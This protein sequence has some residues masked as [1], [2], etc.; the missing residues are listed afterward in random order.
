MKM[1][2][3]PAQK[4]L[5]KAVSSADYIQEGRKCRGIAEGE[6]DMRPP[7]ANLL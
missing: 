2:G 5:G 1:N 6:E 4:I 7:A 3:G